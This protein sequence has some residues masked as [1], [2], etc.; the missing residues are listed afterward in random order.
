MM[1]PV[2]REPACAAEPLPLERD[3]GPIATDLL[4]PQGNPPPRTRT[5]PRLAR[6]PNLPRGQNC[7]LP[8]LP[9]I[10][11]RPM[12]TRAARR[13]VREPRPTTSNE[14]HS[15]GDLKQQMGENR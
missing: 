9:G 1:S 5:T 3:T 8:P 7:R 13:R 14:T 4:T 10:A 12:N 15:Y 2:P 6:V 11:S